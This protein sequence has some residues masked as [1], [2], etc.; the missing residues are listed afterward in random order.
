MRPKYPLGQGNKSNVAYSRECSRRPSAEHSEI[1][2]QQTRRQRSCMVGSPC[3]KIVW[4]L[5]FVLTRSPLARLRA[6][7]TPLLKAYTKLPD[8]SANPL[9]PFCKGGGQQTIKNLQERC[10]RLDVTRQTIV[11]SPS[12]PLKVLPPTL[13]LCLRSQGPPSGR[14]WSLKNGNKGWMG[15]RIRRSNWRRSGLSPG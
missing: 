15:D 13:K 3:Q 14:C 6:G 1:H 10:P 9:C 7:H 2:H 12:P 5:T 8:P 4:P 11:G